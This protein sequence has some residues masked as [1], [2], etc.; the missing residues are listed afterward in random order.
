MTI[1]PGYDTHQDFIETLNMSDDAVWE[2]ARVFRELGYTVTRHPST[3]AERKE[4]WKEHSDGGDL[5][6]EQKIEVKRLGVN[7]TGQSDWPFGRYFIVDSKDSFN[8]KQ[9]KPYAYVILSNDN[10][11]I[12]AVFVSTKQFWSV[13]VRS[14]KR[15]GRVDKEYYFC[16]ISMV[17]FFKNPRTKKENHED[18]PTERQTLQPREN[19]TG[20]G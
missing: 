10:N 17:H 18:M 15:R 19:D 7:F 6:V 5:F 4:E 9:P 12:A 1:E 11:Y 2:V 16:P 3:V 14:D 20:A 13:E 8:R